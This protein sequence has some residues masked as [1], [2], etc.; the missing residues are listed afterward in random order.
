[1]GRGMHA[2]LF[3]LKRGYYATLRFARRVLVKFGVTPARFDLMFA[4]W[5]YAPGHLQSEL[6]RILGVAGPTV[7][8]MLK[9]LTQLGLV[10]RVRAMNDGREKMVLLTEKGKACVGRVVSALMETGQV[11]EVMARAAGGERANWTLARGQLAILNLEEALI[12]VRRGFADRAQL[13]Y[14][15]CPYAQWWRPERRRA[16]EL[17]DPCLA[18][19]VEEP[20]AEED[21]AALVWLPLWTEHARRVWEHARP[22][23]SIVKDCSGT[24]AYGIVVGDRYSVTMRGADAA[25]I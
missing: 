23:G 5:Q 14:R 19:E 12:R 1:L 7:S 18:E 22:P 24:T 17:Y 21:P 8:R 6:R 3:G 25:P 20:R 4:L 10:F 13:L 9:S 15:H 11:E 16:Y 2:M